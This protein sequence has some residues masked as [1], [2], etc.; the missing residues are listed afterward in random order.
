[1]LSEAA[2]EKKREYLR[3]YRADHKE[4]LNQYLRNWRKENKD[5]VQEYE[6]RYWEKKVLEE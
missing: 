2:R 3:K 4:E 1:M 6:N 5:K